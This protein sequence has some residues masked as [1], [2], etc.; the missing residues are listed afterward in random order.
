MARNTVHCNLC[1]KAF[2]PSSL[3]IH[4]KSCRK[5]MAQVLVPCQYCSE[6]WPAG[7]MQEHLSKCREAIREQLKMRREL[8]SGYEDAHAESEAKFA[9][10]M[11][12]VAEKQDQAEMKAES[13]RL[14][15]EHDQVGCAL[16]LRNID[17]SLYTTVPC[18]S[19][20]SMLWL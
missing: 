13:D 17:R 1:G 14:H 4:M 8:A 7:A 19:L 5:K 11:A 18:P 3:P 20:L 15:A 9:A 16:F 12:A 6:E 2:F 10:A